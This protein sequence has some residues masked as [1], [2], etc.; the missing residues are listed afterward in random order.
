MSHPFRVAH[1]NTRASPSVWALA[2]L[3]GHDN[4]V[5]VFLIQDPPKDAKRHQ[6]GNYTLVLPRVDEPMVAI[7]IKKGIKFRLDGEGEGRV[8]WTSLFFRGLKLIVISAYL[9]YECGEG[10]E[11]L[12][13]AIARASEISDFVLLGMD[14]NGHSPLWGPRGT[15]VDRVG[16]LVEGVLSEGNLLV[17][18]N[19]DSPAT[20][21]SDHGDTSWIDITAASPAL[22]YHI[23]AWGVH[24]EIEVGSDH[25]LIMVT[26]DEEVERAV[27][28]ESRN[29]RKTDWR[30][31]N[32]E[33]FRSLD[34]TQCRGE[35][36]DALAVDTAVEYLTTAIQRVIE[37]TVPSRRV[38]A[39]SRPWWTPA[40][41]DLRHRMAATRRRWI[42]TGRVVDREEFLLTRRLFRRTLEQAKL[43]SWRRL[44]DGTSTVDFW[45]LYRRIRR[46]GT[47]GAVEDL[48]QGDSILTSDAEKAAALAAVFF[49]PLPASGGVRQRTRQRSIEHAWST[50][51]PPGQG[52]APAV[53]RAEVILAV[54]RT[55]GDSA[56]GLDGIPAIVYRRCLMTVLPWLVRIFQG[57][58][59]LGHVPLAWRTAKVIA[60]R[61]PGKKDYTTPRSYRPISLLSVMGKFLEKIMC[62]RLMGFLESRHLLSPHQCGFRRGRET[63]EACCRLTEA[64][65]A[66]FRQRHQVQAVMLDIQAA[67]DTVWQAGLLEKLRRKGVPRYIV[68]WT[69]GFLT[70]RRSFLGLGEAEVEIRPECGVPQGSPLSPPLFLVFIDDLLWILG[71]IREVGVQAFADDLAAWASGDFRDGRTH[72]G[73]RVALRAVGGWASFWRVVFSVA[74]CEAILFRAW[75]TR[76]ERP[77][78]ARLG[79]EVIA[80][81]RVVRYLGVWFDDFLTWGRQ[82]QE[83]LVTARRRL[84]ALRRCI[85]RSW[86]LDP[87]TFLFFVRRA[88]IPQM[89]YGAACWASVLRVGTRLGQLD[90][91][92]ASAARM[93]FRLERTTSSEAALALAG[94]PPARIHILRRLCRYMVRKDWG[95]L[96]DL[97]HDRLPPH[98]VSARELGWTWFQRSVV[99]RTLSIP[100][101][102]T[103]GVIRR[104][105]ERALMSEWQA[106]WSTVEVGASLREALPTVGCVWRPEDAE[107]GGRLDITY[108]ARFL[109]GHCHLGSFSVPWDPTEWAPCPLCGEDF[110]R[111][112]LVWYCR[113]VTQERERLLGVVGAARVGDWVWLARC[114]GS[115]LGRFIREVIGLLESARVVSRG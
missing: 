21:H 104:A 47:V 46:E 112:H 8:L 15:V 113:G 85:G 44:C 72:R 114:R 2:E 111:E 70:G 71:R 12:T 48:V 75:Q 3:A 65:T 1:L 84:W 78:E 22:V 101:P 31:F 92:L 97:A 77:F 82:V 98:H 81:S 105:M 91:V 42:L 38:C 49:P 23:A 19:P 86:G 28:R 43:T 16:R 95:A 55:R 93:A 89:F 10:A 87:Y 39:Y 5:D 9:H 76:I 107:L 37:R 96:A 27:T 58:V 57:C 73:L 6:W 52:E 64:V 51:R 69:Q 115:R 29:W 20:F 11:E 34:P 36:L 63:E 54:R 14:S 99:G 4:K 33:L 41:T 35:L 103:R 61:K 30:R 18:N 32:R 100:F 108:A 80:H 56:P 60:L 53:S 67:Y 17:L 66:A 25:R 26:I 62:K 68:S 74:K 83:L 50:H 13:R 90:A 106:R 102:R 45:A 79:S 40:L 59:A 110:T 7:L 24:P 109:T 88:L 94:L